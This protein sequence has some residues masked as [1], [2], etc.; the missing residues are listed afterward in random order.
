L[1][2]RILRTTPEQLKAKLDDGEDVLV[3]D[4]RHQVEFESEPTIISGAIHR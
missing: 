4:V 2:I 1:W 3:A